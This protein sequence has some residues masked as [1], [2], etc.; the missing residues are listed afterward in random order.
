MRKRGCGFLNVG[1][2]KGVLDCGMGNFNK[3]INQ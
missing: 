1:G 3:K 2:N